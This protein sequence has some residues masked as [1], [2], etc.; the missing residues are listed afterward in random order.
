MIKQLKRQKNVQ[1]VKTLLVKIQTFLHLNVKNL[2]I[3]FIF[4]INIQE[5]ELEQKKSSSPL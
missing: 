2:Q 3:I 5:L 4:K 1:V